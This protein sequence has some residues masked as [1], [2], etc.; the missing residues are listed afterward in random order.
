MQSAP[1]ELASVR[2]A[3]NRPERRAPADF[4]YREIA[5]RMLERLQL[6]RLDP[7]HVL[8]AGCGR[9][10]D[11]GVLQNN[12][13]KAHVLGLDGSHLLLSRVLKE[14]A[15]ADSSLQRLMSK[16]LFSKGTS[17][18]SQMVSADF[19]A[20][21]FADCA[22]AAVDAACASAGICAGLDD[23]GSS[24]FN[25]L[26]SSRRVYRSRS[27]LMHTQALVKYVM[28]PPQI[29]IPLPSKLSAGYTYVHP[30]ASSNSL[31][32]CCS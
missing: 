16:W 15:A 3:F 20:T 10:A 22:I 7:A 9:G 31:A 23:G 25:R 1:I 27:R 17:S 26:R 19:G 30:A 13:P 6:V 4:V 32:C 11:L 28:P 18:N 2:A 12:Y 5:A 24:D 14:R 29:T 8:D 21:P